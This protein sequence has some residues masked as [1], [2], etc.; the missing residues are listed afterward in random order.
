M[1]QLTAKTLVP[2]AITDAML[3]SCTVAEPAPGETA[4]NAATAYAVGDVAVRTTVH[5]RYKRLIAG[6][7]ATP[8]ESD[9]SDPPVWLDIGATNRWAQFDQKVGTVTS[10]PSGDLVTVLQPGSVEGIALLELTGTSVRVVMTDR[11][12]GPGAVGVYDSGEISLEDVTPISS[13][14]DWMYAPMQHRLSVVLADLPGQFP[15]CEITVTVRSTSGAACGVLAVGR[16]IEIGA[17]EYDAGAGIINF[18]K[19]N[20]DGFGNREWVEG[21]WA[22][23]VTLPLLLNR[24]DF[25]RVHRQLARL[26]STPCIYIGSSMRDLEPLVCYGVFRDLYITVPVFPLAHLALEVDGLNNI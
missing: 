26:R 15:S 17:T 9:T 10:V 23:R 24:S 14:Y 12:A 13:V 16:V 22:N 18:G 3:V 7:T 5:K 21:D 6:T 25:A 2:T 20:D 11:P 19:V 1:I 8:P 4:W